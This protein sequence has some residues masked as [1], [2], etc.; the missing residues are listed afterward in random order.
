[1]KK[2]KWPD[3]ILVVRHGRSHAQEL[4]DAAERSG[5]LQFELGM[6]EANAPLVETGRKQA[7]ARG[8]WLGRLPAEEQPTVVL[9]SPFVRARQ[10]AEIMLAASGICPDKLVVLID[11]RLRELHHGDLTYFTRKGRE[12]FPAETEKFE[13]VG[14][15]EYRQPNGENRWD[16]VERLRPLVLELRTRHKGQR[17]LLVTH[18]AVIRCLR[19]LLENLSEEKFLAAVRADDAANCSVTSY[20][21][22]RKTGRLKPDYVPYLGDPLLG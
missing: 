1:M 2:K 11:D 18:S 19:Y 22:N 7:E 12:Q 3:R 9:V 16:V 21:R 5:A 14:E 20:V 8:R 10:T 13:K 15:L 4:R 17:V 6:P